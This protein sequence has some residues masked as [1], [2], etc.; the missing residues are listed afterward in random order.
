MY[1][2]AANM[3]ESL[4]IDVF[5]RFRKFLVKRAK[6]NYSVPLII[7]RESH[8]SNTNNQ[9]IFPKNY[10]HQMGNINIKNMSS[11]VQ[12]RMMETDKEQ[13]CLKKIS[14]KKNGKKRRKKKNGRNKRK[15][16]N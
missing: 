9:I 11:F 6:E 16:Y 4:L 12:S 10:Q 15:V 5:N 2:K 1:N 3:A 13:I 8:I 14:N 7:K